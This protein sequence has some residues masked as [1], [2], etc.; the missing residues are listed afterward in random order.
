MAQII[1]NQTKKFSVIL[2]SL[3]IL[4]SITQIAKAA[5]IYGNIYD[6]SLNKVDN[7]IV[8]INT[9][10]IQQIVA[11][12]GTYS[13]NV[14][15][16]TYILKAQQIYYGDAIAE[17]EEEVKVNEEGLFRLDII[18]FPYTEEELLNE[19]DIIESSLKDE[20]QSFNYL[21]LLYASI[22]LIAIIIIILFRLKKVKDAVNVDREKIKEEIKNDV[23]KEIKQE[24]K[25]ETKVEIEEKV[26][27]EIK[28]KNKEAA[29]PEDLEKII[30]FIK[31]NDNRTTQKE[32]RLKFPFSEAKI[33][34]M[35]ADL[36]A[37]GLIKKLKK[38]RGN[39]I[40]LIS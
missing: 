37:R 11:E 32:I 26:K 20:E 1:L 35:I 15:E 9:E 14:T 17:A 38:G 33:S 30:N 16:G 7:V 22:P 8:T 24:V 27:E 6:L 40:I 18:L 2:L 3:L 29:L 13:F 31:D 36:E 28:E 5:I 4:I 19:T 39:I 10:P 25:E 34:L 12:N 21:L 23:K